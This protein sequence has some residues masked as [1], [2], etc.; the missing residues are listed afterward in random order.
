MWN[1]ARCHALWTLKAVP[2]A[3][4]GSRGAERGYAGGRAALHVHDVRDDVDR[5]RIP[6]R[7]HERLA[8]SRFGTLEDAVL[9]QPERIQ[10]QQKPVARHAHTPA[11]QY[12]GDAVAQHLASSEVEVE[13]MR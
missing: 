6:R 4:S 10:R 2:S 3:Q 12:R 11:R 8:G 7:M 5:A 1:S 13:R 9:L